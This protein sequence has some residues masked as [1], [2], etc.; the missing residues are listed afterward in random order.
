MVRLPGDH[1]LLLYFDLKFPGLKYWLCK[2]SLRL[3]VVGWGGVVETVSARQARKL[4]DLA[5][6]NG[7]NKSFYTPQMVTGLQGSSCLFLPINDQVNP[8]VAVIA[9]QDV[10]IAAFEMSFVMV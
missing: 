2:L 7:S 5:V 3:W 10:L 1:I 8:Y 6:Q 9:M 4:E